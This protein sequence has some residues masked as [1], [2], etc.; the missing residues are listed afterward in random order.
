M[1]HP[2]GAVSTPQLPRVRT[3]HVRPWASGYNPFGVKI[4]GFGLYPEGVVSRSPGSRVFERTLGNYWAIDPPCGGIMFRL[5]PFALL[6]LVIPAQ[7]HA[8]EPVQAPVFI[9]GEGGYH[10]YRI[11]S[12]IVT[13]KGTVLAF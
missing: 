2:G 6:A 4:E 12:V 1:E 13:A 8:A 9:A 5:S 10:T 3:F 7:L 11:P